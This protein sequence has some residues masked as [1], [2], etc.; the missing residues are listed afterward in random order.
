MNV[1]LTANTIKRWKINFS[2]ARMKKC[3]FLKVN[4]PNWYL[5]TYNWIETFTDVIQESKRE[6]FS[7]SITTVSSFTG[8][9]AKITI[10]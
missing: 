6:R 8:C 10:G 7:M 9:N 4:P 2:S 5:L 3:N 1:I